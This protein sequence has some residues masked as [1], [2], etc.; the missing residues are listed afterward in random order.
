MKGAIM[1]KYTSLITIILLSMALTIE[2]AVPG[3]INYQGML[4]DADGTPI[5]DTRTIHFKLFDSA[6]G[7]AELWAESHSVLIEEGVF[8]VILGSVT[9]L[10]GITFDPESIY[11]EITVGDDP[12]M[13]PRSQIVSQF[14]ALQAGN[15]ESLNGHAAGDFVQTINDVSPAGG[16]IDLEAGSNVT[17]SPDAE[18]NRVVISASGGS[19]GDDLGNHRA[20][21]NIRLNGHWLSNDGDDEG[22]Q[23]NDAGRLAVPAGLGSESNITTSATIQGANVNASSTIIASSGTIRTGSPSS[24]YDSGDIIAT[25]DLIADDQVVSG[26]LMICGDHMAIENHLGVNMGGG[27]STLYALQ[28]NG[29]SFLNGAVHAGASAAID[30]HLGVNFGGY[31][32]TYAL[33]VAGDAYSTGSWLSSDAKFKTNINSINDPL[34]Q[35]QQLRGVTFDWNKTAYP[36][37]EFS[38][39]NQYGLIAQEVEK[40]FPDMVKTDENGDKAVAYYQLIPVLLEAIKQQQQQINTLQQEIANLK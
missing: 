38:D 11:L 1:L 27:Y 24:G 26:G 22:I 33:R 39:G 17:I 13:S 15:A 18:N 29:Q 3:L 31:S 32:T 10:A 2:A 20:T 19:G 23:I 35:L 30:D 4:T 40:V 28:V 5:D 36:D 6:S 16:N 21:Q 34:A 9:S 37:I 12:P 8:N 25:D 14:M 7:G